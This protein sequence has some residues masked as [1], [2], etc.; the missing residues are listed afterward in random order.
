MDLHGIS[1][2]YKGFYIDFVRNQSNLMSLHVE[3]PFV[4]NFEFFIF[5]FFSEPKMIVGDDKKCIPVTGK[6]MV[7]IT[8]R[9]E[10]KFE[11]IS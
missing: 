1:S 10:G 8:T 2:N 5:G 4:K 7:A 3:R 11:K 6:P 9:S